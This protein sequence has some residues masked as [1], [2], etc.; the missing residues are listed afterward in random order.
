MSQLSNVFKPLTVKTSTRQILY[1]FILTCQFTRNNTHFTFSKQLEPSSDSMPPDEDFNVRFEKYQK[2][3]T[4][5]IFHLS[6]GQMGYR[7]SLR[8]EYE[9]S[10]Q[11][12]AHC[13]S[14]ILNSWDKQAEMHGS[15]DTK[16]IPLDIELKDFGKGR[17]AFIN[18]IN[19]KEGNGL[20]QRVR[21][22]S[23]TT[24]LKFGGVRAPNV[25]RL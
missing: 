10:F 6:T 25:R 22:I 11:T 12:S 18:A 8:G 13:I 15:L 21:Y 9:A 1:K 4:F 5:T 19:G 14:K 3:P 7:K 2:L 20:R 23:D 24:S 17:S 16:N